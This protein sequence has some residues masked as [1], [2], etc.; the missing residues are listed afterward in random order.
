MPHSTQENFKTPFIS[1]FF[2][3]IN[4]AKNVYPKTCC[5]HASVQVLFRATAIYE[6]GVLKTENMIL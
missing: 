6:F 3:V 4:N 2:L 5:F 1:T